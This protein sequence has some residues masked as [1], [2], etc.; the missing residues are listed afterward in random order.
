MITI[1]HLEVLFEAVR[2]KDEELFEELFA[3]H[4]SRHESARREE[5]AVGI[6]GEADRSLDCGVFE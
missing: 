3:R 1:E 2:E 5:H 4:I 6:Q